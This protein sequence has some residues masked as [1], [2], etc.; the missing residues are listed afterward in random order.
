MPFGSHHR[1]FTGTRGELTMGTGDGSHN[2]MSENLGKDNDQSGAGEQSAA[3]HGRSGGV[4]RRITH[5]AWRVLFLWLVISGALT[6]GIFRFVEPTYQ[7]NGLVKVESNQPDLFGP[8]MN[9]D[10]SGSQ[11]SYIQTEIESIRSNPVLDLAL[12][13][14]SIANH[15]MVKNSTDPK[16]EL[17]RKLDLQIIPNTHWIRVAIES[18]NP[19]EARDIVN[20]VINAYVETTVDES[21]GFTTN[22]MLVKRDL[23][24]KIAKDFKAY[25]DGL[26]RQI[27]DTRDKLRE[28]AARDDAVA[29]KAVQE[30]K[31]DPAVAQSQELKK[32]HS[33]ANE[34][35]ATFLR[36]DLERYYGM[37]D[38]INRKAEQLEF[39]VRQAGIIVEKTDPAEVPKVPSTDQRV[40]YMAIAPVAVLFSLLGLFLVFGGQ[41]SRPERGTRGLDE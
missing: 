18:T 12:S 16:A 14:S 15:P 22:K 38:Q 28:L 35:D 39:F 23:T 9:R 36:D 21:A 31:V 11:P 17:R 13:D 20:A 6:Y 29:T 3:A 27:K 10:G 40:K 33:H 19:D 26:S 1:V 32:W 5:N 30:G 37:F 34:I 7:A 8:S 2:T 4:L 41:G 25:R 24:K